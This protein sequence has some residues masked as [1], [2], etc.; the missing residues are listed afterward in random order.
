MVII[1]SKDECLRQIIH[2]RFSRRIVEHLSINRIPICL[3]NQLYLS[4]I[5]YASIQLCT[6]ICLCLV[7]LYILDFSVISCNPLDSFTLK[8]GT[9]IFSRLCLNSEYSVID[10]DSICNGFFKS[11]VYYSVVI[12]KCECLRCRSSCQSY[13][14]SRTEVV[15]HLSPRAI[16]RPV[17][18]IYDYQIKEIWR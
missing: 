8:D 18:F 6:G 3:K 10:I 11:I 5:D 14:L 16:N 7:C 9:T 12:E 1:Q 2:I 17:T 4:R 15:K 13:H